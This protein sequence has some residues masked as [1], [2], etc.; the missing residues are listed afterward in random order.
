VV[1][2]GH[3]EP[4]ADESGEE[5][6]EPQQLVES[7]FEGGNLLGQMGAEQVPKGLV[8]G[9]GVK[10]VNGVGQGLGAGS[11]PN[12]NAPEHGRGADNRIAELKNRLTMIDGEGKDLTRGYASADGFINSHERGLLPWR[13]LLHTTP[14]A[15]GACVL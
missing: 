4:S 7:A 2:D 9:V 12:E 10:S 3:G 14:L 5:A 13:R 8:L 1:I 11:G 15:N 6:W